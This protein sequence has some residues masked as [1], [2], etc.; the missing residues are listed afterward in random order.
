MSFDE[1][2]GALAT[3]D[4]ERSKRLSFEF[5][6]RLGLA[7]AP[8]TFAALALVLVMRQ[9]LRRTAAI[10]AI[11]AA[12]FAYYVALWLGNGLTKDEVLSPLLA[13]WMPQMALV[14]TTILVGLP[15]TFIRTRA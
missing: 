14:L 3:A 4:V 1:L 7:G 2:R 10:A 12:A 8:V 6:K 15:R 11:V 9:H 13:A 5:H